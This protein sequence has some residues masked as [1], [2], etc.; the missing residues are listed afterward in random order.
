M[1]HKYLLIGF[2]TINGFH[3]LTQQENTLF[4]INIQHPYPLILTNSLFTSS[5][6]K[7]QSHGQ[8]LRTLEGVF[9]TKACKGSTFLPLLHPPTSYGY[10]GSR[11]DSRASSSPSKPSCSWT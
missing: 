10:K 5:Y 1:K 8:K 7:L 3:P 6:P 4:K 9:S 11:E 2:T